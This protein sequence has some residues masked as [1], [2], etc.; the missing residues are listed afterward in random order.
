M[1]GGKG[2]GNTWRWTWK[3]KFWLCSSCFSCWSTTF[4]DCTVEINIFNVIVESVLETSFQ[5]CF[6]FESVI[7][8]PDLPR[9]QRQTEWNM[10]TRSLD[11]DLGTK[12]PVWD[13]VTILSALERV[14][15]RAGVELYCWCKSCLLMRRTY[16]RSFVSMKQQQALTLKPTSWSKRQLKV[17]LETVLF[18]P[19]LTG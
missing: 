15:F 3:E 19:S 16:F 4:T 9:P 1:G 10:D 11:W 7:S 14:G 12:L 17:N 8:N 5:G 6:S 13:L 2:R 18:W